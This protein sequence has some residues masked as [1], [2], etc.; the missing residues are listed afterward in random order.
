MTLH[1]SSTALV[2]ISW[3]SEISFYNSEAKPHGLTS[4]WEF[5]WSWIIASKWLGLTE[6]IPIVECV[7]L[8]NLLRPNF[9]CSFFFSFLFELYIFPPLQHGLLWLIVIIT[10]VKV[11][12]PMGWM[13]YMWCCER[14]WTPYC[15]SVLFLKWLR[16]Y[17][18][19][20]AHSIVV[21]PAN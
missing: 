6:K 4:L 19:S 9:F 12:R 8:W 20:A 11:S 15:L 7:K 18:A 13:T 17:F 16:Y 21:L 14:G 2:I 1:F 10:G 5:W 3:G